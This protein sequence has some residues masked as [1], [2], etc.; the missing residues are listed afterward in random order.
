MS[1]KFK[2]SKHYLMFSNILDCKLIFMSISVSEV[3]G[4]NWQ[5]DLKDGL[6]I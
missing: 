2:I 6:H 4:T 5:S 1:G 3:I